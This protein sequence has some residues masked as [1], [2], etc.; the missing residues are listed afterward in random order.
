MH[1]FV[2]IRGS[3]GGNPEP[4]SISVI[5][6]QI[7]SHDISLTVHYS[8]LVGMCESKSGD[9]YLTA[10]FGEIFLSKNFPAMR[11]MVMPV[12]VP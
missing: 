5:Q 12:C 6:A 10:A 4:S 9:C 1:V 3:N 7:V 11:V 2:L 8:E